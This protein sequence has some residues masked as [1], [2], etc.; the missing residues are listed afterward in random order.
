MDEEKKEHEHEPVHEPVHEHSHKKNNLTEKIRENPWTLSTLILGVLV[1]VL[2]VMTFSGN[3]TGNVSKEKAAD[4]LV[5][6][7]NTVADS[8]IT[9]ASVENLGDMYLATV[10]YKGQSI[11]VYITKD[12]SSYTTTLIPILTNSSSSSKTNTQQTTVPKSDKPGVELYVFAYCPYG[13]QME[14]A[15]IPAVNILGN[16]TNFNIRYIGDMH[17]PQGC[18]GTACFEKTETERQ[19]CIEKNY[20]TKYLDYISAFAANTAIGSC[21]GD[22]TCLTPLINSIY[23]TLGINANTINSCMTSN[24]ET[25]YNAEVSNAQSKGVTGSPTLII[26]GVQSQADR[27]P[28]GVKGAICNAFNNVPSACTQT[29]ST[30]QTSA[31]F[32]GGSSSTASGVQCATA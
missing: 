30:N 21:S 18:S 29:L 24:G 16:N 10:S 9:L 26:N 13:L 7:L 28:E 1:V 25:L 17:D 14:K 31:G 2:L 19:L 3:L 27:S 22:A 23:S 6:Y 5:A 4:N 32:G 11:P 8:P 15:F 12:G 20:P